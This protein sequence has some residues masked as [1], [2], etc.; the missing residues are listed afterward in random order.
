MIRLSSCTLLF[1]LSLVFCAPLLGQERAGIVLENITFKRENHKQ[2]TIIFKLNSSR[3]PKI[4]S[5]DGEKPRVVFDFFDT[6]SS[7]LVNQTINTK[8]TLI[9]RIRVGVHHKPTLKTRVVVDLSPGPKVEVAKKLNKEDNSLVITITRAGEKAGEKTEA[10][11]KKE[12]KKEKSKPIPQ[13]ILA[14]KGVDETK[15]KVVA[16][17]TVRH[18]KGQK[19][20]PE[21]TQKH[22]PTSPYLS[23][24]TFEDTSNKGEM[25]LFKLNDF[26]PPIVFGIEKGEPRVVCDFLGTTMSGEIKNT[27]NT[28]GKYIRRIRIAKHNNPDKIRIVLDLVPNSNYDLQQVFFKE[29]N[30]FVIIINPFDETNKPDDA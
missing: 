17:P 4:F 16:A 25:V 1:F 27:I 23:E 14:E 22:D 18:D 20:P 6:L 10:A 8:G 9:Q 21:N 29:D 24:V 7:D 5:I 11:L 28:N 2:E 15:R 30:L 19:E 13:E 26:Y 12:E 3:V